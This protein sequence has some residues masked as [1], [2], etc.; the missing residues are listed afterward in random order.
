MQILILELK[1]MKSVR[2]VAN[3][4]QR[5]ERD[6]K[7]KIARR[8]IFP[9]CEGLI[10][11]HCQCCTIRDNLVC[12]NYQRQTARVGKWRKWPE[13][14]SKNRS[15]LRQ[16]EKPST[17]VFFLCE[18]SKDLLHGFLFCVLSVCCVH[19]LTKEKENSSSIIMQNFP[20]Q[21]LRYVHY[22]RIQNAVVF[23]FHFVMSIRFCMFF[24]KICNVILLIFL[25]IF[26]CHFCLRK[27]S[28][29]IINLFN[30]IN[31]SSETPFPTLR[32]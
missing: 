24:N 17:F 19:T 4:C 21:G 25:S 26:M 15:M 12:C 10:F 7:T 32:Q 27:K 9:S 23:F 20:S 14:H 31:Q 22:D 29:K 3:F 5:N 11:E 1:F 13:T 30:L 18:T 6:F 16:W 28:M 2:L 8:S